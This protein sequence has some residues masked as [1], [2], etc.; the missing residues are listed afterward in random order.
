MGVGGDEEESGSAVWG[1]D[2]AS[3]YNR[4]PRVIPVGGKVSDHTAGSPDNRSIAMDS[5]MSLPGFQ[6]A[7]G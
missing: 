7:R 3:A 6:E 2:V 4:P 1:G 5:Q